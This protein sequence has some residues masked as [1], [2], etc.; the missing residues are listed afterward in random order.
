MTYVSTNK[1][2]SLY[3]YV[4]ACGNTLLHAYTN[5]KGTIFV[6]MRGLLQFYSTK[7]FPL[8]KTGHV[9]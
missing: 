4:I 5:R 1:L 8:K 3:C 7:T 6:H 2:L 9:Y